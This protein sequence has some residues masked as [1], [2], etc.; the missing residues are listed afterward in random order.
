M[1]SETETFVLG[2]IPKVHIYTGSNFSNH[3]DKILKND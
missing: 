3:E 1:R 2:S